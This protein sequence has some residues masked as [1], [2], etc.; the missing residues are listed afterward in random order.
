M[1]AQRIRIKLKGFDHYLLDKSVKE[2]YDTAER[3]GSRLSGPMP[4]PTKIE[5]YCVLR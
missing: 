5:K 1:S 2:I 3:N 4:L